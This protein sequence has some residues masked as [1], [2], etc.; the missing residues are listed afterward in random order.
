MICSYHYGNVT[1]PCAI[2]PDWFGP[3]AV[4]AVRR[5]TDRCFFEAEEPV[6]GPDGEVE[7][8]VIEGFMVPIDELAEAR[9]DTTGHGAVCRQDGPLGKEQG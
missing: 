9:V 6:L 3:G 4:V 8:V 2:H 7:G 1:Q 5:A